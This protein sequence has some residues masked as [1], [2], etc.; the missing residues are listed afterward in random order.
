MMRQHRKLSSDL[1]VASTA[2]I[3]LLPANILP[4]NLAL[5]KPIDIP[6]NPPFF[7]FHFQLIL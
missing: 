3:S 4:N 6:R 2:G 7:M 5:K 1:I